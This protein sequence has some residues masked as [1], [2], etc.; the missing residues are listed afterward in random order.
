MLQFFLESFLSAQFICQI[1]VSE[2]IILL[3]VIS[4]FSGNMLILTGTSEISAGQSV[5]ISYGPQF[6]KDPLTTRKNYLYERYGFNCSCFACS[7]EE[8]DIKD[9]DDKGFL[10]IAKCEKCLKFISEKTSEPLNIMQCPIC[11]GSSN[12][13][14]E[15]LVIFFLVFLQNFN[16]FFVRI[17]EKV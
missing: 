1:Y 17:L 6:G 2:K 13:I 12:P 11:H 14:K 10:N 3:L 8:R 4:L 5:T 7:L 15:I 16:C 9:D